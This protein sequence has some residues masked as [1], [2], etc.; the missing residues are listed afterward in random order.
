MIKAFI[1]AT[2]CG[3]GCAILIWGWIQWRYEGLVLTDL[4]E[5][6]ARPVAVV[7][8][9]GIRP[10]GQLSPMLADRMDTAIALY[11][12]G[13]VRKLLV[14]G[15]N[16]FVDYDE[17]TAMYNYA[18]ARGVPAVDVVRD[19]A[20]RRTYDTCYRARAIFGVEQALLVTQRFH[21]PRALFTCR[22]LGV[23]A[24]GV[25]A[26]R[27]VYWS[28]PYYRFRDAFATLRAW[29]DVKIVRPLPVLGPKEDMGLDG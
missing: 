17:P 10:G 6:P 7:F 28:N 21:L 29:W 5:V 22:N 18:V 12:A 19:F 16:R 11:R 25:S 13:K 3:A 8:G 24:L 15:D 27:R 23:D 26:D 14:S 1:G 2:A 4:A 20:G 9:A